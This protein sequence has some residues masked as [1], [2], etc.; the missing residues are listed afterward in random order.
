MLPPV[1]IEGTRLITS[2]GHVFKAVGLSEFAL[3]KRW[4]MPNGPWALVEP[5]LS[6]RK[7]LAV[8]AGY[9]GPL[10]ARVFRYAQPSNAFGIPPWSYPMS[11][12]T[13]FTNFLGARGWYVDWT[14]GDS[15]VVL[16]NPDGP[17]G[18]QQHLNEFCAA[19]VTCQNAL[20]VQTQNEPFKN[21]VDVSRVVPPKWGTYMI[22][23]GMYY[24]GTWNHA[25]DL[26]L[27]N[28]HPDRSDDENHTVPKF[29]GKIFESAVYLQR[30]GKPFIYD[31][32]IGAD[33]VN[34]PGRR[35]NRP[36]YWAQMGL[37]IGLTNGMYFHSTPG[38]S[39]DGFGPIVKE[40]W[41]GFCRG[42]A[43]GLSI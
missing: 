10:V 29:V 8:E 32:P 27:L 37:G 25:T 30:H 16:P 5:I 7:A 26:E 40:C 31:E 35:C 28:F 20:I 38:L 36:D 1:H 24:E 39:S 11:A 9:A 17:S 41:K 21:G 18:Q 43:A 33:E 23:S 3:F 4:L 42:V 19:L 6:E 22:N 12:V 34:I 15:Q 14:A 13:D 2:E